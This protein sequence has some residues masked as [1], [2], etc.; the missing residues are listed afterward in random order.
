MG[1]ITQYITQYCTFPKKFF[2]ATVSL[3]NAYFS[4]TDNPMTQIKWIWNKALLWLNNAKWKVIYAPWYESE[5][6]ILSL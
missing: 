1:N 6:C 3:T 4:L 5:Q 2:L